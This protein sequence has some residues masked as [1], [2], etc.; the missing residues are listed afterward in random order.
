LYS[1]TTIKHIGWFAKYISA[2]FGV[3]LNYYDI[4]RLYE[5]GEVLNIE[6]G[7]VLTYE[8]FNTIQ[9]SEKRTA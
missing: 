6:T 1:R 8:K 3:K 7:E 9:E 5:N 2:H 4:K